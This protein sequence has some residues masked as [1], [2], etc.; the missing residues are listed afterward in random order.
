MGMTEMFGA[1]WTADPSNGHVTSAGKSAAAS[2]D[3]ASVLPNSNEKHLS[4]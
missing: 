2:Q 1:Q 3:L 4:V